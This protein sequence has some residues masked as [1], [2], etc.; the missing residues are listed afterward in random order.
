MGKLGAKIWWINLIQNGSLTHES[1]NMEGLGL[2]CQ[3]TRL[4]VAILKPDQR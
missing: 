4:Q 1:E 2:E 3:L